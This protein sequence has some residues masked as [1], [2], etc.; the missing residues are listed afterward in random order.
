MVKR[1][2]HEDDAVEASPRKK[3]RSVGTQCEVPVAT[4]PAITI[5][6]LPD[7]VMYEIFKKVGLSNLKRDDKE[8]PIQS[9]QK[10]DS[11]SATEG[12]ECSNCQQK[13]IFNVML[14]CKKWKSLAEDYHIFKSCGFFNQP[15]NLEDNITMLRS[16]RQFQ[17][18][19]FSAIEN[20]ESQLLFLKLFLKNQRRLTE[21]EI[22]FGN[23]KREVIKDRQLYATLKPFKHFE[24]ISLVVMDDLEN[25]GLKRMKFPDLKKLDI[26][27]LSTN[28]ID[29]DSYIEAPKLAHLTLYLA[30]CIRLAHTIDELDWGHV[31]SLAN[32]FSKSISHVDV[33]NKCCSLL[34]FHWAPDSLV[35]RYVAEEF[36]EN[37]KTFLDNRLN[38]V[39]IMHIRNS[40]DFELNNWILKNLK[41]VETLN[42]DTDFLEEM[43]DDIVMQSVTKIHLDGKKSGQSL[44]QY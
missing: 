10:S 40:E 8:E 38:L 39:Q 11:S 33:Y 34:L 1:K 30:D 41:N 32:H 18:L 35:L 15:R 21:A 28:I 12:H 14:V 44:G 31:M 23:F 26:T 19:K 37:L 5:N 17:S 16:T 24:K 25:T 43:D 20:D 3:Y 27:G 13:D 22:T 2:I 36:D 9:S 6:D 7:D 4:V 29:L 42:I